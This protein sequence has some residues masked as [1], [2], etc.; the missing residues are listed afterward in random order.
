MN[1]RRARFLKNAAVISLGGL[2]AKVIGVFYRIP[3][4]NL[5]GG[6]GMG[7]YQMAYPLFCL[8][9]TF[10]SA[11]IPFPCGGLAGPVPQATH[12]P[13]ASTNLSARPSNGRRRLFLSYKGGCITFFAACQPILL[14]K[15]PKRQ[16]IP[17]FPAYSSA[18]AR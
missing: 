16:K 7:L 3:L 9:L 17:L 12:E 13:R 18:A 14:Y 8:L 1:L 15:P 2:F 11:G 10:S 4:A 6:Y 5:L